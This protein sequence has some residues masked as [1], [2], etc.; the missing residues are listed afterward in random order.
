MPTPALR[1]EPLRECGVGCSTQ[2]HQRRY[3]GEYR[4][5]YQRQTRIC[6]AT[7]GRHSRATANESAAQG[8]KT[9]GRPLM[10]GEP[11]PPSILLERP[12]LSPTRTNSM[13]RDV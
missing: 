12:A 5:S 4:L 11:R 10:T 13:E 1:P 2:W 3:S 8:K 9:A 6:V 7:S